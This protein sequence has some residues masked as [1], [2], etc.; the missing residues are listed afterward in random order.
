MIAVRQ[1]FGNPTGW[2]GAFVGHLM[3]LKNRERSEWVLTQ[4]AIGPSDHVLEIGFGSGVDV[5]RAALL[6]R[7]VSGIDRSD[8]MLRQATRRNQRT[9]AEGRVHLR[10]GA[11]PPL[12]FDDGV[13]DKA[14]SIN[15]FQF[16]R[17]PAAA[18]RELMR[19]MK[20]GG[21]VAVA[22]QPRNKGATEATSQ[23]TGR[24]IAAAL[25]GAGFC[26]V[27]PV[28]QPLKPVSTA[29]ATARA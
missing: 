26:D 5:R 28:F 7:Q 10:L 27:R 21:V 17:D 2:L 16:W 11:V 12:P 18:L 24:Q 1:Q 23:E 19:V 8:V 29:C 15:A 13:F 9:I 3:A 14:F 22:V 20:P 4:L 6:A 25:T